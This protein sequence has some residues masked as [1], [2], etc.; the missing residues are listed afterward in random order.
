[1]NNISNYKIDVSRWELFFHGGP[2]A[3]TDTNHR[4]RNIA[5][6]AMN[7]VAKLFLGL[8]SFGIFTLLRVIS[9]DKYGNKQDVYIRDEID[10]IT[11]MVDVKRLKRVS[12]EA[13]EQHAIKAPHVDYYSIYL[14]GVM[15]QKKLISEPMDLE[16]CFSDL[17]EI[18]FPEQWK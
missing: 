12:E 8:A 13:K 14:R 10:R 18:E 4:T 6:V 7:L 16:E 11:A 3:F 9:V 2:L 5:S 1:M 17:G 15:T